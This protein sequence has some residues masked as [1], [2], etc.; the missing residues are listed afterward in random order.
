MSL[1][2]ACRTRRRP[3]LTIVRQLISTEAL[4]P[5]KFSVKFTRADLSKLKLDCS[6][7]RLLH[8]ASTLL[9]PVWQEKMQRTKDVY[10]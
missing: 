4:S 7:A 10:V 1:Y 2:A 6:A 9:N 3:S 8:T 5:T